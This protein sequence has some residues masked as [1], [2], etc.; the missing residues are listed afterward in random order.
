[1]SQ[2]SQD[3]TPARWTQAYPGIDLLINNAGLMMPPR[4]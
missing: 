3:V 4:H 2:E 1:V